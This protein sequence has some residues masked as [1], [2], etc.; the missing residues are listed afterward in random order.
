MPH[1]RGECEHVSANVVSA[2]GA[3]L[4]RP[5]RKGV[6]NIV[7]PRAPS[8]LRLCE[9]DRLEKTSKNI[10]YCG[11]TQRPP[12][13]GNKEVVLVGSDLFSLLKVAVEPRLG[14]F[15]ER[16]Q[17]TLPELRFANQQ[18]ICGHV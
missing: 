2:F 6:T 1:V 4:K 16:N 7:D 14:G 9:S 10:P 12:L 5:D 11:V 15:M 17:T 3:G 8:V 18:S 13:R